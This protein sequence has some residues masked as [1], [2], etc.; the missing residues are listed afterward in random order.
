MMSGNRSPRNLPPILE[1]LQAFVMT[2]FSADGRLDLARFRDHL[3]WLILD[4]TRKPAGC[5]VA[6]GTGEL[7]S[8]DLAEHAALVRA[9]VS[10]LA[11]IVPV[12][13]GVGY[14]TKLAVEMAQSAAAAGADGVLVFPP[15]LAAGPQDGLLDHYRQVARAVDIGVMVY[16]R[17]QVVVEP[18]TAVQLAAWPTFIG[19]K[20]GYG[21]LDRL[22]A[23]RAALGP[24]FI[25]GNGM[26][27]AETYAPAY[28]AIGVRSYSPGVVD[29][30]PEL[31]W[32]FDDALERRELA[33]VDRLLAEFYQPLA[34]LRSREAGYGIAI[35]KAGLRLRGKPAG[36]VRPPLVDLRAA[37]EADLARLIER[38]LILAEEA[39]TQMRSAPV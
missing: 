25:F 9:A 8:L 35:V 38:G 34:S 17:D 7:W 13:A 16:Q 31:A 33:L 36:S 29:F 10:E 28:A 6:C 15:Y 27:V 1:G 20:D 32:A 22:A 11:G 14:G 37:D 18:E 12:I 4:S 3:R 30:L 5:F 19:V 2:P 21:D 39:A 26:P 23:I 24:G